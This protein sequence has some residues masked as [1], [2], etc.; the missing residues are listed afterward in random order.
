[1][2]CW[3]ST[4]LSFL[5][6]I[7]VVVKIFVLFLSCESF[8]HRVG[9]K[10]MLMGLLG[11]F[12]FCYLWRYFSWSMSE[13]IGA[14]SMFLKV[15]TAMATEFYGVIHTIVETQKMWLTNVWL[16][17]D[18]ALVCVAFIAMTNV[19]W[20]RRNRWNTCFNYCEKI[21]FKITHIF[22]EGNVC[23]DKLANLWFIYRES[24]HWYNRLLSSIF[25]RLF[26]NKY[27]VLMY[28]FC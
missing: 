6:L 19:P 14:F 5:V 23:A 28:H 20:M 13:F 2:I 16:E 4:W 3:I 18:S 7:F 12:W 26:M 27:S 17:C 1:M 21:R 9:L 22:R 11:G 8:L 24:F 10:F 25:L 15:Q